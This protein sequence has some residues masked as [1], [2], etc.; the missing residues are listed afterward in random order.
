MSASTLHTRETSILMYMKLTNDILMTENGVCSD[1]SDL[2]E[3]CLI[4][5]G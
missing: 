2:I 5:I 4:S 3:S 1:A